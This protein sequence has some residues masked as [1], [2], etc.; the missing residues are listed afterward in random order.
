MEARAQVGGLA[1]HAGN[2]VGID[3]HKRTLSATIVDERGGVVSRAH[4]KVSTQGHQSLEQWVLSFGTVARWGIENASGVGRH[5]AM[6]LCERGHDVRDVCAQRTHE[7]SKKRRQGKSDALDSERIARE[8]LSDPRLP[9]AFKRAGDDSGP[10]ETKELLSLWHKERRSI[11]KQCQQLLNEAE[12]LLSELP[13]EIRFSLPDTAKVRPRLA[14]LDR[15][16]RDRTWD[17]A[18]ALRLRLLDE[19]ARTISLLDA[20][21]REATKQ[22]AKLVAA[23][24]ST[25]GELCG[26]ATATVAELLV[27]VGDPRRFTEGGFARFNGTAPLPASSGEGDGEPMRH[28]FNPGGNRRVNCVLHIM[29]VTQLR[30]DQRARKIYDDSRARGHTK[31]EALRVLRRH[32]SNVAYRR[33]IRDAELSYG[34]ESRTNRAVA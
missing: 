31:K 17:A 20:R 10:D 28:R 7:R 12:T 34:H 27:E 24:E 9:L 14:A 23:T 11:V 18:T 1:E 22:L 6:F 21:E 33:M 32:L 13:Q 29:A 26:L 2:V 3:P 16:D 25:L 15:R 4:F 5:T 19:H 8:T 30:C